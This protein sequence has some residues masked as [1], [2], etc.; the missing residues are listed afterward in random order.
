[1]G[2]LY[3]I[4]S[5]IWTDFL[6]SRR[7]EECC[8]RTETWTYER[9]NTKQESQP[10][11]CYRILQSFW[12]KLDWERNT[13]PSN[14]LSLL[15]PPMKERTVHCDN[16]TNKKKVHTYTK[17]SVLCMCVGNRMAIAE[18]R[19]HG[20]YRCVPHTAVQEIGVWKWK[21]S[22]ERKLET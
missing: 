21:K 12:R 1:M 5:C 18:C 16:K 13:T 20:P 14:L 4:P 7:P 10:V 11:V 19:P 2:T 15:E 9:P 8:L 6:I 22:N 3:L 17:G